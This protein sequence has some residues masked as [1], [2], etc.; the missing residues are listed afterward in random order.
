MYTIA[1]TLPKHYTC[2]CLVYLT[3]TQLTFL[4]GLVL[5]VR[6]CTLTSCN[7]SSLFPLR[8]TSP[9]GLFFFRNCRQPFE[10]HLLWMCASNQFLL[11]I[12]TAM[13]ICLQ[14]IFF[15]RFGIFHRR[16]LILTT[17]LF[18]LSAILIILWI[19]S[20]IGLWYSCTHAGS[21]SLNLM[22]DLQRSLWSQSSTSRC[23]PIPEWL[24]HPS[25]YGYFSGSFCPVP[26]HFLLLQDYSP[27][28]WLWWFCCLPC[29]SRLSLLLP[30][31]LKPLRASCS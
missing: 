14:M 23:P 4:F 16:G 13:T 30:C 21:L 3:C 2:N 10:L 24:C 29:R 25:M 28:S 18:V 7:V 1:T 31:S 11:Y 26:P 5:P 17:L 15:R 27:N 9:F 8:L 19:C 6:W 12:Y 20:L 22:V